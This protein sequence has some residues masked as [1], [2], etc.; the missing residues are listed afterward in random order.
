MKV[1]EPRPFAPLVWD[2]LQNH[3]RCNLWAGMGLGKTSLVETFLDAV[4]NLGGESD[5]TLVLGPL[6]V[7]RDVWSSE[8]LKW[9]HLQGLTVSVVVGTPAERRA[10]LRA[11]AQ[12]YVTNYDNLVWLEAE[13][14]GRPWPCLLYTSDAAD[15]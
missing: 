6:R 2:F 12:V 10:A 3:R 9:A 5:P 11:K 4:Y 8:V 1:Y 15:E 14:A 7:A 13:L